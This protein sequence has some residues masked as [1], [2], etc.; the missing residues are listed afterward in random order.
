VEVAEFDAIGGLNP[1]TLADQGNLSGGTI[2]GRT[3]KEEWLKLSL[4]G[5]WEERKLDADGNGST[6][7]LGDRDEKSNAPN[8]FSN[9]N[10]WTGSDQK[11]DTATGFDKFVPT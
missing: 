1:V 3:R 7:G 8:A 9:A 4:T 5:N 6:I 11:K 2:T 10:E